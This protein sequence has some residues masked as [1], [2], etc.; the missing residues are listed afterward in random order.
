MN[1]DRLHDNRADAVLGEWVRLD[2]PVRWMIF[3]FTF[4]FAKLV[5]ICERIP[6][7]VLL[8]LPVEIRSPTPFHAESSIGF[9]IRRSLVQ[10]DFGIIS[11]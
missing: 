10:T 5:I 1:S 4:E 7:E 11:S 2:H 3:I 9:L 8:P 6:R